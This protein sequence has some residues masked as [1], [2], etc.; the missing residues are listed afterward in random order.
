MTRK[1]PTLDTI[2][3]C[4]GAMEPPGDSPEEHR[5]SYLACWQEL[6]DTG[7]AWSLQGWFG[8]T[9]MQMIEDGQCRT[10]EDEPR[11]VAQM[12]RAPA[13]EAGDD[14]FESSHP[15]PPTPLPFED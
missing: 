5:A 9:A 13:C 12:D 8:R 2:L 6:I 1:L 4:E 10:A 7:L 11:G 14:W 3:I 15:D